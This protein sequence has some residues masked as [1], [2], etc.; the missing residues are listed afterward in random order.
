MPIDATRGSPRSAAAS[1]PTGWTAAPHGGVLHPGR[2]PR[3][4][5]LRGRPAVHGSCRRSRCRG[6]PGPRSPPTPAGQPAPAPA[7][8]LGPSGGSA[9]TCSALDEATL[10]F[11]RTCSTRSWTSSPASTCTSAAT[12]AR[13][14]SGSAAAAAAAAPARARPAARRGRARPGSSAGSASSSP[15]GDAARLLG[16]KPGA[17]PGT[18]A[19]PWLDESAAARRDRRAWTWCS[20]RTAAPTSTIRSDAPGPQ[21]FV[22]TLADAY[23][24]TPPRTPA[25]APRP[26]LGRQCQLWTE[27]V[28]TPAQV[29]YLAF[30]RLCAFADGRVVRPRLPRL[31]RRLACTTTRLAAL[32]VT[33]RPST[34]AAR[35]AR[36]PPHARP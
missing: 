6:T 5:R 28:P 31:P 33:T 15:S 36:S 22:L 3:A 1:E 25:G 24:F 8:G 19:M 14:P 9:S 32:G 10:E 27:Y 12:S 4:R 21:G 29:E 35:P 23:G 26:G 13:V 30:P 18:T 2:H 7:R 34:L 11:C 17:T 20:H 16:G